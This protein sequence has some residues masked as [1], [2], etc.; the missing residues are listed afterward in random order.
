MVDLEK[1]IAT[2]GGIINATKS[3]LKSSGVQTNAQYL[4]CNSFKRSR[5]I[6]SSNESARINVPLCKDAKYSPTIENSPFFFAITT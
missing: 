2:N 3:H 1:A 6:L 4:G 5:I